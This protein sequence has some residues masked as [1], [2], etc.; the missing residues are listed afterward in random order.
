MKRERI[1][2]HAPLLG[3]HLSSHTVALFSGRTGEGSGDPCL[4]TSS[5]EAV[6]NP[7]LSLRFRRPV[8]AMLIQDIGP[9][10]QTEAQRT[11]CAKAAV[12]IAGAILFRYHRGTPTRTAKSKHGDGHFIAFFAPQIE[13]CLVAVSGTGSCVRHGPIHLKGPVYVRAKCVDLHCLSYRPSHL[14]PHARVPP[15]CAWC[16]ALFGC[17]PTGSSQSRAEIR[18]ASAHCQ[19][20][21][22]QHRLFRARVSVQS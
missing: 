1:L 9:N 12:A 6:E 18:G 10:A 22:T 2:G 11:Q 13:L 15:L 17:P 14:Q 20:F 21:G 5:H 3:Y 16:P 7:Q 19:T 4:P 8:N